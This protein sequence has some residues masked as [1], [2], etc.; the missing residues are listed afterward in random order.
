MF[1]A[2]DKIDL[3]SGDDA[4]TVAVQ[5]DHRTAAEIEG[6]PELSALFAMTRVLNARSHLR[7][8]G[9]K[10]TEI[11]YVV[12]EAPPAILR[13]A[14]VATGAVIERMPAMV[15]QMLAGT[16][17]LGQV[18]VDTTPIEDRLERLGD[19]S[20]EAAGEL[21][22]RMFAAL[23]RRAASR[24][25]SSDLAMAL[26]MLEDQTFAAPPVRADDELGYWQRVLELAALTGEVLR[27]KRPDLGQWVQTDRAV[28]PFGFQIASGEGAAVM[29][30]TNR[31]QRVVEDGSDES[32]FKLILAAE[33]AIDNPP[34][35]ATGK[36]MPSL[37]ARETI[38]LD[39]VLWRPLLPETE[40]ADLPVVVCGVDGENTFGMIRREAI[41]KEAE[42]P[43]A[44]ALRN[45]AAEQVTVEEIHAEG[46]VILVV[47]GSFYAAEKILDRA[48]LQPLHDELDATVLAAAT[49]ARGLLMITAADDRSHLARF[50]ALV[51]LRHDDSGGRAIS[52]AILL[53]TD[54]E[55]TGTIAP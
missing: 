12:A 9:T 48:F 14:L 16:A 23:A 34:D 7:D 21:A 36:L 55:I 31:A 24:V 11:R 22:D 18:G 35:A 50:A 15:E 27:A 19:G 39:E 5:T 49:P 26:R 3:V 42:D 33:E 54:G 47:G 1:C 13:E 38:E 6:T 25:G 4:L 8:E 46:M 37:R 10:A 20:E 43:G 2:L 29:F 32:L 40:R 41:E 17:W 53:V 30:P 51:Q 45:L 28:I 44:E 52:P